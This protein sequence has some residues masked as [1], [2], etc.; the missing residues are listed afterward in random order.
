MITDSKYCKHSLVFVT[1]VFVMIALLLAGQPQV[2]ADPDVAT[3][4]QDMTAA[5]TNHTGQ[6]NNEPT[7]SSATRL[8][9]LMA[10]HKAVS[11]QLLI[12]P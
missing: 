3:L 7:T 11:R 1:L 4:G 8:E 2:S 6:Q 10:R 9:R 5:E 12:S